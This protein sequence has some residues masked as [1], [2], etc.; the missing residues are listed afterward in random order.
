MI[1]AIKFDKQLSAEAVE[2]LEE[3]IEPWFMFS[4]I[5]SVGASCNNDGR[6]KF[7]HWLRER[8]SKTLKLDLPLPDEGLVYDYVLDDGGI[9][10]VTDEDNKDEDESNKKEKIVC[11]LP[12]SRPFLLNK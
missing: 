8:M 11:W 7:S 9:F 2:R 6:V 3:L 10:N 4:F 12:F 1:V 5:W